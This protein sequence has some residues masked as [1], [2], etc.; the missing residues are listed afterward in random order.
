MAQ[1]GTFKVA[2]TEM[3]FFNKICPHWLPDPATGDWDPTRPTG[4]A[5]AQPDLHFF[6]NLIQ[7]IVDKFNAV[8]LHWA[9]LKLTRQIEW[10]EIVSI[11]SR[12]GQGA[13]SSVFSA[14]WQ[15]PP[16]IQSRP[17]P[18]FPQ[19][20]ADPGVSVVLKMLWP[21][22]SAGG[23]TSVDDAFKKAVQEAEAMARVERDVIDK[24]VLVH[25]YGVARGCLPP[26]Q[27]P[28]L[29]S[30]RVFPDD[31]CVAVI[32]RREAGGA[33]ADLI[34]KEAALA[35]S[36]PPQTIFPMAERLRV[37][38]EVA[39]GLH[40]MHSGAETLHGDVKPAN[41]LLSHHEPP[42]V[43]IADLG[44]ACHVFPRSHRG[45]STFV[46]PVGVRGT[47]TYMAPEMMA[48]WLQVPSPSGPTAPT[49]GP[50]PT[51]VHAT[52][53]TDIH[54]FGILLYEVVTCSEPFG[55]L[56]GLTDFQFADA[57]VHRGAR[58]DLARLPADTPRGIAALLERC[59]DPDR[60]RRPTA[61]QCCDAL[62]GLVPTP[63]SRPPSSPPGPPTPPPPAG[64]G[65]AVQAL[66]CELASAL[67]ERDEAVDLVAHAQ[68][69]H[70]PLLSHSILVCGLV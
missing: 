60:R 62:R 26:E 12:L 40:E 43:R 54:S 53:R 66:R 44:Y 19:G 11:G 52:M 64:E 57:V 61:A 49:P 51:D 25:V 46:A 70:H 5:T 38:L 9:D 18:D 58:P 15:P 56:A 69:R 3:M 6:P 42:M 63:V 48:P 22:A 27:V 13:F 1:T 55:S 37:G 59:W 36:H 47:I 14:Q 50:A 35:A 21:S 8:K 4:D 29:R 16:H 17:T 33:L 67:G 23:A 65:G 34:A 41:I 24:D 68:V 7:Q 2:A 32:M 39:R 10:S 28:A 45:A 31:E 20:Q 30:L